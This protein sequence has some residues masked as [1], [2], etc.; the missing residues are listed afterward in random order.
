[1]SDTPQGNA[2]KSDRK[3]ETAELETALA[4]AEHGVSEQEK[5]EVR[6]QLD[7]LVGER[8]PTDQEARLQYESLH[9]RD[10]LPALIGIGAVLV[11]VGAAMTLF[12][13]F[14]R[15]EQTLLEDAASADT[16]EGELLEEFR[17]E[18]EER[19]TE[20]EGEIARVRDELS[21]LEAERDEAIQEAEAEF[22]QREEEL[23]EQFR[24]R[25]ETER[26]RLEE[27]GLSGAE[28]EAQLAE[29]ETE[30]EGEHAAE[31][32]QL[33]AEHEE[34]LAEREDALEELRSEYVTSREQLSSFRAEQEQ[35]ASELD[36]LTEQRNMEQ[37]YANRLTAG[38]RDAVEMLEAENYEQAQT[39]LSEIE[40]LLEE[41]D[42]QRLSAIRERAPVD[43][44]LVAALDRL[45]ELAEAE[46]TVSNLE[47]TVSGLR[48][49]LDSAERELAQAEEA[50]DKQRQ[51]AAEAEARVIELR[52]EL[53][54]VREELAEEASALS[55]NRDGLDEVI[56]SVDVRLRVLETLRSEPVRS[57]QPDLDQEFEEYLDTFARA[58]EQ[59]GAASALEQA[60]RQL[61]NIL[62]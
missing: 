31:L 42:A 59:R 45:A 27:Q 37:H 39:A 30:L 43:R 6:A 19:L 35:A 13:V 57:E 47:Q 26:A 20:R 51:T 22:L 54:S 28:L 25:L 14:D 53:R 49:Q 1:M 11:A 40:S 36:E 21:S 48:Q 18:A 62:E 52:S 32:E 61:E 12:A 7:S 44:K 24:E 34:T 2:P 8:T 10:T 33:R 4:G 55:E 9:R 16:A 46:E 29:I 5:A 56:A 60:V 41:D 23:E 50:R 3:S 17:A 15:Q 58:H 38:Y